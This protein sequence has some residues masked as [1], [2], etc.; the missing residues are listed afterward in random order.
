MRPSHLFRLALPLFL[1]LSVPFLFTACEDLSDEDD[2]TEEEINGYNQ[3]RQQGE[4]A[5]ANAETSSSATSTADSPAEQTSSGSNQSSDAS[6]SSGAS[7]SGGST[8]GSSDSSATKGYNTSTEIG[9]IIW[10]GK[11]ISGWPETTTLRASISGGKVHLDYGKKRE[12]PAVG[13]V[14]ANAWAIVNIDGRWYAGTFEWLRFGQTEKEACKLDS[15]CGDHFKKDP[16][17][18]WRP[19]SGEVFGLMVSGLCR[20]TKR[21]V[22]ERSNICMVRWP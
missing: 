19:R 13:D 12:W 14:N 6:K 20:D 8:S 7:G 11:D 5:V 2:F 10:K 16:L 3:Q 21:N 9:S 1:A 17:S 15:S 22:Q 18:S 4:S